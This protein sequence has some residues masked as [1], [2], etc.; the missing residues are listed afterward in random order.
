LI[1]SNL[2]SSYNYGQIV[3]N[4]T[5]WWRPTTYA[6]ASQVETRYTDADFGKPGITGLTSTGFN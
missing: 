6:T 1:R 2:A 3:D 5:E 4:T